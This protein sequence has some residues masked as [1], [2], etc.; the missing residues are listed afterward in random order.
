MQKWTWSSQLSGA[1]DVWR[2]RLSG[3]AFKVLLYDDLV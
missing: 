1:T 3:I 2:G